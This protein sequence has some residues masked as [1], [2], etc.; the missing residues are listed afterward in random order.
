M[1][2]IVVRGLYDATCK[3]S[4]EN[5]T[6]LSVFLSS[7]ST[8][9]LGNPSFFSPRIYCVWYVYT[10]IHVLFH[11]SAFFSLP[12]AGL[13]SCSRLCGTPGRHTQVW[14]PAEVRCTC[15]GGSKW[16]VRSGRR[17]KHVEPSRPMQTHTYVVHYTLLTVKNN[18]WYIFI[19][20]FK[21][22]P[23][24]HLISGIF[25]IINVVRHYIL[26]HGKVFPRHQR[27]RQASVY[28]I[29]VPLFRN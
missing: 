22:C 14:A 4:E 17:S 19:N 3:V 29:H 25:D 12:A 1:V 23:M 15:S 24:S 6:L 20:R 26:G 16:H 21:K 10:Y 18:T 27:V 9:W 8:T 28:T 5:R 13:S 7:A 2:Q 11:T